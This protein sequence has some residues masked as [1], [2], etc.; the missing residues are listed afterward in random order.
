M[1]GQVAQATRLWS[2]GG[3]PVPLGCLIGMEHAI[4]LNIKAT[5]A[6]K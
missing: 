2:T 1:I 3:T 6:T 4:E 5:Q